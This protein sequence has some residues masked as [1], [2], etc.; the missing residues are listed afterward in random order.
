MAAVAL[1][2][3]QFHLPQVPGLFAAAIPATAVYL[4]VVWPLKRLLRGGQPEA[5]PAQAL[6]PAIESV[7]LVAGELVA[8][9][10]A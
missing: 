7:E 6:P 9:E 1:G 5:V 8:G 10:L 2:I 3:Q 4:A